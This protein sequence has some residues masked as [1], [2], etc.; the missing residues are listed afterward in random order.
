MRRTGS[1]AGP[2][3]TSAQAPALAPTHGP[4]NPVAVLL[5]AWLDTQETTAGP[6]QPGQQTLPTQIVLIKPLVTADAPMDVRQYAAMHPSFPQEPT[7]DQFFD[8]AQWE[9]YRAL[10]D[11]QARRLCRHD[12]VQALEAARR[13]WKEP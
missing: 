13:A 2:V 11:R 3:A 8:E 5:Y 4:T 9:S 12:V 10:G 6:G 1:S 7:A